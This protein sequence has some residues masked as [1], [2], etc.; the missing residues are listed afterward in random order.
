MLHDLLG[1]NASSPGAL[2][3]GQ[4]IA[5]AAHRT[6]TDISSLRDGSSPL[7]RRPGRCGC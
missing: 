6:I 2:G 4:M 5:D 7:P 3:V 1:L